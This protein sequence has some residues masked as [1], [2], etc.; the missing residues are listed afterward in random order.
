MRRA[1]AIGRPWC[2]HDRWR[3]SRLWGWPTGCSSA[4]SRRARRGS[5]SGGEVLGELDLGLNDS[6]R[7]PFDLGISEEVTEGVLTPHLERLGGVGTRSTRLSALRARRVVATLERDG[8]RSEV[9]TAPTGTSDSVT[10]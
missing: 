3:S 5:R 4:A 2:T 7:Y 6:A 1:G 10:T 9:A 8:E